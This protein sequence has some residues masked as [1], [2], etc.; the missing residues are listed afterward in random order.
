MHYGLPRLSDRNIHRSQ[1][2]AETK[3]TKPPFKLGD[4]VIA[5]IGGLVTYYGIIYHI[6]SAHNE[7]LLHLFAF[8]LQQ[9][10]SLTITVTDVVCELL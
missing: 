2:D 3:K 8:N 5:R 10:I 4:L 9:K 6:S 7:T 1:S